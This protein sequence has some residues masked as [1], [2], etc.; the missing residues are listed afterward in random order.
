VIDVPRSGDAPARRT[1]TAD[2][3][4]VGDLAQVRLLAKEMAVAT[5]LDEDR[6]GKLTVAVNEIV[7]NAIV[8]GAPPVTVTFKPTDTAIM[9]HVLDRG[10]GFAHP[11][12]NQTA[13]GL[14]SAT[15]LMAAPPSPDDVNGRG[16]WLAS[17]LCDRLDVHTDAEGTTVTLVMNF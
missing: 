17:Q 1:V 11:A 5:G 14:L 2:A 9:I 7:T 16:L 10:G 12:V 8:H 13:R 6:A 15:P 3:V 4:T